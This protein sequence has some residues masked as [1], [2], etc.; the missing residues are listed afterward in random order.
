MTATKIKPKISIP[1][2]FFKPKLKP[3]RSPD[4]KKFTSHLT[5]RVNHA[6]RSG[7][8]ST[9]DHLCSKLSLPSTIRNDISPKDAFHRDNLDKKNLKH[10][11]SQVYVFGEI[12]DL[13]CHMLNITMR[14]DVFQIQLFLYL[15]YGHYL[16]RYA[17]KT[18]TKMMG[19]KLVSF[20]YPPKLFPADFITSRYGISITEVF[21]RL[22][23]GY[24]ITNPVTRRNHLRNRPEPYAREI[25]IFV[26]GTLG[27]FLRI[28]SALTAPSAMRLEQA[29]KENY[30]PETKVGNAISDEDIIRSINARATSAK[31]FSISTRK[32][33]SYK[34]L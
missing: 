6:T 22:Y 19:G 10:A 12:D 5:E 26:E 4:R 28:Y 32:L 15:I 34:R 24:Y 20:T 8:V 30:D 1:T 7:M 33:R 13:I 18:E 11:K 17:G 27:D 3:S 31:P 2:V 16:L 14:I 23:S 29:F 9:E 25:W 21:N